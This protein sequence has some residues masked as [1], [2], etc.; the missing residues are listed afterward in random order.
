MPDTPSFTTVGDEPL[1]ARI[2]AWVLGD[3]SAFEAAELDR[4]CE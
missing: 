3:T 4:L 1:E 2:V